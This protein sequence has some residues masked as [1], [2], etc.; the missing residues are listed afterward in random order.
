MSDFDS[1]IPILNM[2][3][4]VPEPKTKIEV[5]ARNANGDISVARFSNGMTTICDL[6]LTY[7]SNGDFS[8]VERV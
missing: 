3:M 4:L 7:D 6:V 1:P 8:K 5:E 2:G